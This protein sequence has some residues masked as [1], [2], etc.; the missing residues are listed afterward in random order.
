MLT[1]SDSGPLVVGPF[2]ERFGPRR[3]MAGLLLIGSV[4]CAMTGLVQNA[5]GLIGLRYSFMANYWNLHDFFFVRFVIGILGATFVP[6]Q[7]WATQMF[8]PSVVGTANALTGG[9]GNMGGG[10]TYLVM[11]AIYEGLRRHLPVSKAWRLVFIFPAAICIIMAI[12]D[13]YS[14]PILRKGTG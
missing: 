2:C 7:F 11:P 6:T 8:S 10:I 1:N 5:G 9:W 13:S 14:A 4:P 12:A 3:V